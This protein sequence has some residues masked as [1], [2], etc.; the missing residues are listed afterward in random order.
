MDLEHRA[1]Q[2]LSDIVER[3]M[4]HMVINHARER[5]APADLLAELEPMNS[6]AAWAVVT[7]LYGE[8]SWKDVTK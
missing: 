8:P 1:Q 4:K 2:I 6:R 5:G 7:V 3:G